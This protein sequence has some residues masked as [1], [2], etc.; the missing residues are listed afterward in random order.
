M[1]MVLFLYIGGWAHLRIIDR[2]WI[3]LEHLL[4]STG[5]VFYY[6]EQMHTTI[7]ALPFRF[8]DTGHFLAA[9]NNISRLATQARSLVSAY[10][11]NSNRDSWYVDYDYASCLV[12]PKYR[13]W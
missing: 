11:F 10:C 12:L 6:V 4:R 2:A 13:H 1:A 8:F 3:L 7:G 9:R 5:T